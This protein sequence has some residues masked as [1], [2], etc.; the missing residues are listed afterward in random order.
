MVARILSVASLSFSF[1]L[2]SAGCIE[3]ADYYNWAAQQA[4]VAPPVLHGSP[5]THDIPDWIRQPTPTSACPAQPDSPLFGTDPVSWSIRP[6]D[7]SAEY[8]V[9]IAEGQV[10]EFI[11]ADGVSRSVS[12]GRICE[13]ENGAWT[14]F[15]ATAVL[16]AGDE[17]A[18]YEFRLSLDKQDDGSYTG[19]LDVVLLTSDRRTRPGTT[20]LTYTWE[21]EFLEY[22]ASSGGGGGGY[23]YTYWIWL[24]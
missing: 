9:E 1:A 23:S 21:I 5:A 20:S 7:G 17:P 3:P 13:N 18:E 4:G 24:P 12:G 19:R 10:L 22:V 11:D 14:T 6:S 15:T 2:V 8:R 16:V